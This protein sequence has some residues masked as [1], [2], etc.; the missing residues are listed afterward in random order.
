[1]YIL[2]LTTMGDAAA[3]LLKDGKLIAAAEEERFSRRK[4]HSGFP[5]MAVEYCL[6]EAGITLKDVEHV[7]LYWKPW[8]LSHKAW[9]ALR[10]ATLS[11]EMFQARIDR[12]V[13]QISES[14]LGMF[15]Y[16]ARLRER[17]GPSDFKFH[18]MDHHECHAASCFLV[19]PFQSAAI[20]TADGT[21]EATTTM[22]ANGCCDDITPRQRIKLPNSLGQFY[23]S[24]TNFLGFDMFGGD[25]WKVMGLA[26]YG[27]PTYYDFFRNQ[28]VTL[29]GKNKFRVHIDVLDHHLA[30]RYQFSKASIAALGAPRKPE[31]EI[32]QRHMDIAASAQKVVEDTVLH[33]LD[34]L[35]K[36]TEGENCEENL[37]MAGGVM[38]NSVMNGRIMTES[39]FK[40]FYIQPAAG[41]A[42]C[43]LGAALLV[44]SRK[45][46][47]PAQ[48]E[49]DHAYWG[50]KFSSDQCAAARRKDDRRWR[51]HRLVQRT[52]GVRSAR[53]GRTQLRRR[54][55]PRRHARVAQPQGETA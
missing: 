17:F 28:V 46:G 18:Y 14:Y 26:A 5:W 6:A 48:F 25:E 36:E 2:G 50:P 9:Q 7:A 16:P 51:H 23:S 45:L 30:K 27:K 53:A 21:G 15:Q 4:H 29:E 38:F 32:S 34:W 11:W 55:A 20:L 47:K 22:F 39:K 44:W 35:Y 31:E 10:S 1:M 49:M 3:S 12:G 52:H 13:A 8:V 40:N 42:G 41:D 54:P 43:S 19:S 33:L 24:V 37:C